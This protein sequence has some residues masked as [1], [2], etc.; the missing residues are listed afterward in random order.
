LH[1]DAVRAVALPADPIAD[2]AAQ[3]VL[4]STGFDATVMTTGAADNPARSN[5]RRSSDLGFAAESRGQATGGCSGGFM[6]VLK[7][8]VVSS[9]SNRYSIA[10]TPLDACRNNALQRYRAAAVVAL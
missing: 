3:I 7:A 9:R 2:A 5:L 8:I 6:R 1:T 10:S 4:P